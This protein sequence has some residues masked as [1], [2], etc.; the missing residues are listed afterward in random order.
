MDSGFSPL[1]SSLHSVNIKSF[2]HTGFYFHLYVLWMQDTILDPARE[3]VPLEC[4]HSLRRMASSSVTG[5]VFDSEHFDDSISGIDISVLLNHC[6]FRNCPHPLYIQ[7][8]S[9]RLAAPGGL[10]VARGWGSN[11]SVSQNDINQI[12]LPQLNSLG[13]RLDSMG[14]NMSR[15]C[16]KPMMCQK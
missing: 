12:I 2:Y 5:Q 10:L 8:I 15:L 6:F 14:K 4:S 11:G 7:L 1:A 3:N 16:P 9:L 13:E